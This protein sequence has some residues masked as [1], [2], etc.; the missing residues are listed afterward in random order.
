MDKL[1]HDCTD[2]LPLAFTALPQYP[3]TLI[4]PQFGLGFTR[5]ILLM[6]VDY[7]RHSSQHTNSDVRFLMIDLAQVTNQQS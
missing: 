6:N 5:A 3:I 4:K 7:E 2:D 1:A